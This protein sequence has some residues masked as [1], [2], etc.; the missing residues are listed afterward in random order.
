VRF[1]KFKIYTHFV[2]SFEYHVSTAWGNSV[3]SKYEACIENTNK[4]YC[5]W[6]QRLI[7]F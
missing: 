4:T 3:R 6:L 5:A 2:L 7:Q 1:H